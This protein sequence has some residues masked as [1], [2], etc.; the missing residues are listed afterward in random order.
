MIA[1]IASM[2][3]TVVT[4][5]PEFGL[6]LGR[7]ISAVSEHI[8][9]GVALVQQPI[10][11]LAVVHGRIGHGIMPDQLVLGVRVHMVLVA[12]EAAAMLLGPARI[13]VLLPHFGGLLPPRWGAPRP[14]HPSRPYP[15]IEWKAQS[16]QAP[17]T[18]LQF[19]YAGGSSQPSLILVETAPRWGPLLPASLMYFCFGRPMHHC[20]GVDTQSGV[21]IDHCSRPDPMVE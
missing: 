12:E 5:G 14:A 11:F 4:T 15:A 6:D 18:P 10:Q 2:N 1:P 7:S 9:A 19:R 16:E 13:A 3:P 8:I 17:I 21:K 20:S